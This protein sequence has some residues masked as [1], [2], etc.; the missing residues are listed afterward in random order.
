V[1]G[2]ARLSLEREAPQGFDVLAVDAFSG[3][4]IPVHLITVEAFTEYLRHLKPEGVIAFHVSNRFLDLKPVLL[5]IAEHHHLEYAYL[6]ETGD[7]GGTTSDWVLITRSKRFI[8]RPEIVEATEPVAPRPE[9]RLWTD[10]FNNLV[11]VFRY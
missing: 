10:D 6:R 7:D 11:Q 9:W 3:D 2:D 1:L 4:S 8:L 5:A